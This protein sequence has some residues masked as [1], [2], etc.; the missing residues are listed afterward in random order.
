MGEQKKVPESVRSFD[1]E[2]ETGETLKSQALVAF[3]FFYIF[4]LYY[5]YYQF[6]FMSSSFG[7]LWTLESLN[8]NWKSA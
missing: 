7:V 1:S 2:S 4:L 6:G 5:Y 3:I 8:E